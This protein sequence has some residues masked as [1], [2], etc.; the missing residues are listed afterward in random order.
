V[1]KKMDGR[2]AE[3]EKKMDGRFQQVD[4]RFDK[5]ESEIWD[6]KT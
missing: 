4:R 3:V 1:E 5:Q 2:F 6:I